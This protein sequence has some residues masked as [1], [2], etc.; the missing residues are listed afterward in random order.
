[1]P[2]FIIGVLGIA[3]GMLTLNLLVGK[4]REPKQHSFDFPPSQS[5]LPPPDE[6]HQ[7]RHVAAG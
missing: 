2:E 3:F 5:E 7:D 4:K 1:M 6:A